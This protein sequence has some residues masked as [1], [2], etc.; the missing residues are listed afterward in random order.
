MSVY[1]QVMEDVTTIIF[2]VN[3]EVRAK[4]NKEEVTVRMVEGEV[5]VELGGTTIIGSLNVRFVIGL[6]ME[7]KGVITGV[8]NLFNPQ[9]TTTT[10][11]KV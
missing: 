7:H 9:T 1:K 3:L 11:I 8:I 4:V 6:A 10:T 2:V 5:E